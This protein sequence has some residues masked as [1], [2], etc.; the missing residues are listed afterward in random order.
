MEG[1]IVIPAQY[2]EANDFIDGKAV[3]KI[4]ENQYAL[5]SRK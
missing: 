5:I 3:V 2:E 4:K 1:K